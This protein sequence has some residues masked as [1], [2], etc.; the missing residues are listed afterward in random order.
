MTDRVRACVAL[1]GKRGVF[2]K[3]KKKKK[4]RGLPPL[5]PAIERETKAVLKKLE[6]AEFVGAGFPANEKVRQGKNDKLGTNKGGN[7][8]GKKE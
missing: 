3:K 2:A 7:Y 6:G 8:F 4:N 5:C 1:F